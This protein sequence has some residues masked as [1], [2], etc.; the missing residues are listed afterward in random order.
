M[1]W[2]KRLAE[3]EGF[4][5]DAGNAGKI[6]ERHQVALTE[7]EEAFFNSPLV[8]ATDEQHSAS[9]DRLYALG[10]TDAARLLFVVFT[11]RGRLIRVISARDMSRKERRV[12][13]LS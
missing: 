10:Q 9:E 8:V 7:C 5:W 2:A 6:W 1:A 11:I 13:Q 4:Q 12:Y 3:C